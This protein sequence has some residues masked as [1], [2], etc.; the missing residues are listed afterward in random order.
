M[1]FAYIENKIYEIKIYSSNQ[2]TE[3]EIII[4]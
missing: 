3:Q 2:I 4:K 1:T